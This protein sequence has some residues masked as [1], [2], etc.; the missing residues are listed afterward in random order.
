MQAVFEIFYQKSL[1]NVLLSLKSLKFSLQA[2]LSSYI[3]NIVLLKSPITI[4]DKNQ[5][6]FCR[7]ECFTLWNLHP[8][9]LQ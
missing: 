1:P 8:Y 9:M 6:N 4:Y 2:F 5:Q 3:C 7:N